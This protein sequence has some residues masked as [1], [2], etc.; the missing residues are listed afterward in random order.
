MNRHANFRG[1]LSFILALFTM[2]PAIAQ[3]KVMAGPM[4]GYIEH[5]E[6]MVWVMT[7]C[8]QKVAIQYYPGVSPREKKTIENIL[9]SNPKDP[10]RCSQERITKFTLENLQ[11]GITY[12][13]SILCDGKE[14]KFD[15]QL[16]FTTRELWEWRGPAP[17]FSFLAGSCAYINDS[18]YDRPGAPYGKSTDIFNTMANLNANMMFWLGDNCYLR[19]ADYS[20]ESGIRYRY[21]QSRKEKNMQKLLAAQPNYAIWDDH[22]YGP[23]NSNQSFELKDVT[24]ECFMNYWCNKTY[25]QD[26]KGIYSKVSFSDCDFFLLDCR[27]FRDDS[28]MDQATSPDKTMLGKTQL[29]WL[30]NNLVFSTAA[31]KFI[32]LGGQFLNENTTEETYNLY[33]KERK[34]IIDFITANKIL[35]VVFIS[36]DRHHSEMIRKER[37]PTAT[38]AGGYDLYDITTSP[39]TSGVS[40]VQNTPEATNPMRVEGTLAVK[41][42]FCL[43][44]ISGMPGERKLLVR[45]ID[46]ENN[47]LWEH[48]IYQ[49][50]LK[51]YKPADAQSQGKKKKKRRFRGAE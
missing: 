27:T 1:I 4:L 24:K 43:F 36:G 44:N 50:E 41:Q 51:E 33:K 16:S 35:G 20:S 5:R 48:T 32:C 29:E 42:N 38:S 46:A 18:A 45:C 15:Y 22:D 30:K 40:D 34:E 21:A 7:A 25:G 9:F 3:V 37:P 2:M 6:A 47:T 17:D 12:N 10:Q 31:F 49:S 39:L 26:G 8:A 28:R 14:Q 19:E 13:Y 23:D 11:P